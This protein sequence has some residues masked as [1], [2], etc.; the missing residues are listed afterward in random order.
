MLTK[1]KDD[2]RGHL[3]NCY[4][5]WENIEEHELISGESTGEDVG[6]PHQ[7]FALVTHWGR[8]GV[9]FVR[10]SIQFIHPKRKK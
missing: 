3:S 8:N 5:S 2:I 9:F 10:V 1:C 4:L 6:F 7:W